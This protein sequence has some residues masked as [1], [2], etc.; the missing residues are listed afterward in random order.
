VAGMPV[1]V[2]TDDDALRERLL[3][4][5]RPVAD[6][7]D[8]PAR[9]PITANAEVRPDPMQAGLAG[10]G[11]VESVTVCRYAIGELA[12]RLTARL[13]SPVLSMSRI[14]GEAAKRL[15]RAIM[16]APRGSGPNCGP[17]SMYGVEA[18][19]LIVRD[20][21][22]TQ[23]VFVRYSGSDAHGFDDGRTRRWLTADALRP[24]LVGPHR[25]VHGVKV[26]VAKLVWPGKRWD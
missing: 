7:T 14:T 6:D 24:L 8:C 26:P 19:V 12:D 10:L 5:V 11:E 2:L 25:P 23:E 16:A 17:G 1:T 20:G 13:P 3:G 21:V 9:H 22:R 18:L 15:V 4:S